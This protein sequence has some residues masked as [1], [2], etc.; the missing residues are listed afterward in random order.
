MH[1]DLYRTIKFR[2]FKR[3][4]KNR[5]L[6]SKIKIIVMIYSIYLLKLEIITIKDHLNA[7]NTDTNEMKTKMIFIDSNIIIIIDIIK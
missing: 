6:K 7:L 4:R 2:N 1:R 3:W 5:N